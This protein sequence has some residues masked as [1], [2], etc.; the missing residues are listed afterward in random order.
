MDM[1]VLNVDLSPRRLDEL[2]RWH[3]TDESN[4][5]PPHTL[6][7]LSRDTVA[8]LHELAQCRER[9]QQLRAALGRV[10]WAENLR[11]LHQLVL[12]AVGPPP[13]E[14]TAELQAA[15]LSD[16]PSADPRR[17]D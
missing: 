17:A 13:P 11:E 1:Q 9:L 2:A 14:E 16:S 15:D 12:A 6:Q 10:F 4:L 3:G 7:N 5:P 8:A